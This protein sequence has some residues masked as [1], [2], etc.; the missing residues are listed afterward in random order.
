MNEMKIMKIGFVGC[1]NMA[2]AMIQGMIAGQVF[3]PQ[4][5]YCYTQS[6]FSSNLA[7]VDFGVQVATKVDSLLKMDFIVLACK[8]F[9]I[10][11]LDPS[12]FQ[13]VNGKI[14]ISVLAGT[15][16][17]KL[18]A[19]FKDSKCIVR[20][21]PNTASRVQ[22]GF[23]GYAVEGFLADSDKE[24]LLNI[25]SS[26]GDS[27]EVEEDKIDLITAVSG[28]GPAYIFEFAS[29]MI[30]ASI[31][32]GLNKQ[33]AELAVQK[34]FTG[35]SALME[36]SVSDPNILRDQVT[37]KGGTTEAALSRFRKFELRNIVY[38]AVEAAKMRSIELSS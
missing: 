14:L 6:G 17:E 8:P 20:T 21:M 11:N 31:R 22:Q 33:E 37:S 36:S 1:G 4:D 12:V 13:V 27:I 32:L 28:S 26:F 16:I 35:A 30:E 5:I 15:K 7:K 29:A 38:S 25:L 24:V 3:Q 19:F 18:R 34:T 23:T 10:Q 2:R 9:Q